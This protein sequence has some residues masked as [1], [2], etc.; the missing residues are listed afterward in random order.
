MNLTIQNMVFYIGVWLMHLVGIS[1]QKPNALIGNQIG[2]RH[3][4][5]VIRGNGKCGR[6]NVVVVSPSS[7]LAASLLTPSM[8]A[9][10]KL[11]AAA[12]R[13]S[14]KLWNA[15]S[16]SASATG[17]ASGYVLGTAADT[18]LRRSAAF[19]GWLVR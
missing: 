10:A 15:T 1:S 12:V 17:P 4:S 19:S 8:L 13:A 11:L 16:A 6:R 14:A 7:L 3:E 9:A 5:F 2:E 18:T